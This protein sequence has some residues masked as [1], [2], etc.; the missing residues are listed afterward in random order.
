M[1]NETRHAFYLHVDDGVFSSTSAETANALMHKSSDASERVGFIVG[2]RTD[3]SDC[4]KVVGFE[5]QKSPA[6]LRLPAEKA[7]LLVRSMLWFASCFIV[8]T[9]HVRSILGIWVWGAMLKRE[10]LAAGNSIFRFCQHF[11]GQR[12]Q[13]WPTAGREF[14]T[15]AGFVLS[16]YA[17]VGARIAPY[18]Y[19]TNAQGAGEGDRGGWGIVGTPIPRAFGELLF[20]KGTR[21]GRNVTKLD[22]TFGVK[23][24][25]TLVPTI[26]FTQLPES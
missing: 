20:S 25:S 12:A 16:L 15:M 26:P 3:A 6:M 4:T 2:D 22:G 19:A 7:S 24:A 11:D 10:A 1:V 8:D 13:W 21:P 18:V 17:H 9:G 23:R 14:Q 5:F